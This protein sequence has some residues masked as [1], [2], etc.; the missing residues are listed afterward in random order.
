[1]FQKWIIGWKWVNTPFKICFSGTPNIYQ[2]TFDFAMSCKQ[3]KKIFFP[4]KVILRL[5]GN[6]ISNLKKTDDIIG[7][8]LLKTWNFLF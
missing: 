2:I 6:G 8:S 5:E 1:M 7:Q 3:N 4:L